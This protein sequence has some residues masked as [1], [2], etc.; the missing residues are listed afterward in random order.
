[1]AYITLKS[2]YAN[3]LFYLPGSDFPSKLED[4]NYERLLANNVIEKV[5][6]VT[7]VKPATPKSSTP[8]EKTTKVN[9]V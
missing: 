3:N 6:P 7:P 9:N 1:M 2:V 5:T 8:K 4:V